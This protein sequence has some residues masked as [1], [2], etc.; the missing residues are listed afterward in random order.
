LKIIILE[1][2]PITPLQDAGSRAV[3]DFNSEFMELGYQTFLIDESKDD[4]NQAISKIEPNF[5]LI[6]RPGLC[7]RFLNSFG[8]LNLGLVYMAHDLHYL[9]LELQ[10]NLVEEKSSIINKKHIMFQIEKYC[11]QK[12]TL[13]LFPTTIEAELANYEFKV[14]KA[15]S[16]NYFSF[17]KSRAK[18]HIE[19]S[20]KLIFVGGESHKPN[21]DGLKW[22]LENIWGNLQ[23]LQPSIQLSV[24]GLW[25]DTFKNS[26]S[27]KSV[28]FKG[29][30]SENQLEEEMLQ[31]NVGIAPLRFGA[32]MKRKTLNYLSHGLPTISTSFGVQGLT[33]SQWDKYG[34]ILA[35]TDNEWINAIITLSSKE[36]RKILG[37]A[38]KEFIEKSFSR[39]IQRSELEKIAQRFH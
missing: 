7:R 29:T 21:A 18:T 22:F 35:N 5:L 32:G 36:L 14:D 37:K 23:V 9:R 26:V 27:N 17:P 31:N 13:S 6:S 20:L 10:M 24:V 16:I 4:I 19:E 34:T 25:S 3:L 28:L 11:V 30:L 39:E 8:N 15:R 1:A 12:T 38:G 33:D 2:G